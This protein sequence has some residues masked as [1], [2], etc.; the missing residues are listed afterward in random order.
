MLCTLL[1]YSSPDESPL[2]Q[3]KTL[4][5]IVQEKKKALQVMHK[6]K[7]KAVSPAEPPTQT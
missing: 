2:A 5:E 4:K 6:K 7:Q 3:N 1:L